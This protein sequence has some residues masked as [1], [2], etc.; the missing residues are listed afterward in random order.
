ME[1]YLLSVAETAKRLG[2]ASNRNFVYELIEKGL[3]KSIK[4]KSLKVRNSEINRFLEW[5]E[6][7]DLSN[8]NNIKELN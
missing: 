8:L 3:L 4:L 5:A 6:G 2:V 7:K 1:D